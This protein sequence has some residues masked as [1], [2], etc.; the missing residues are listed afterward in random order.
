M[1]FRGLPAFEQVSGVN[2][3]RVKAWRKK[4]ETCE[5]HE[6]LSYV[7]SAIRFI[8]KNLP[9]ETYDVCHCHFLIPT[10][11]VAWYLKKR[12]GLAYIVTIH[13]SDVPGYNPDRFTLEHHFTK[14]LLRRIARDA[15]AVTSP[16]IYLQN[17]LAQSIGYQDAVHIPNGIDL[18][19][20]GFDRTVPKEAMILSSGRLL[21]RKGFQ[22]LICAVREISIDCEVHIAGDG[23]Y[24][25]QLEALAEG[26]QTKIVFHG[27]LEKGSRELRSL[28]ERASIYVLASSKENASIALLEGMAAGCAVVSTK[29]S[30]CPETV[31]DAGFLIDYGDV[32]A[33]REVLVRLC[34]DPDLVRDYGER[35]YARVA[36]QFSWEKH[37]DAYLKL[38]L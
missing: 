26:S 12:H 27:W 1:G 3:Y 23:P 7:V 22:T 20:L 30:G 37:V 38:L 34:A 2:V 36:A 13:G 11:L 24:R 19:A 31:G 33:V 14:P 15:R 35:S 17:L 5:T 9:V 29:V 21:E 28:Y 18:D 16:S 4:K 6:M 25:P 8:E 32:D 10:G